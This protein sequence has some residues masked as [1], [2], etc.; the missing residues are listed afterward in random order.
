V[1]YVCRPLELPPVVGATTGMWL[2]AAVAFLLTPLLRWMPVPGA[3]RADRARSAEAG[4]ADPIAGNLWVVRRALADFSEAQFFGNEWASAAMILGAVVALAVSPSTLVYGTGLFVSVLTAQALTALT[5]VVVW[6]SRW[7]QLG[8]YP[9]FVP[10]VSVAPA[11][12]LMFGGTAASIVLGSLSGAL[13]APPLGAAIAHRLPPSF[14]PFVGYV[15]SMSIS[16]AAIVSAL[17][18]LPGISS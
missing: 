17:D 5:G 14:H 2:G 13:I 16:T 18:L 7:R 15:A 3:W 1:E 6:R 12:V 4:G 9:T 11:A 8:F 10:V